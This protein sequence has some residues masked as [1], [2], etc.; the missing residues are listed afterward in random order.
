MVN[1]FSQYR[2]TVSD[3]APHIHSFL[4]NENKVDK[5]T[6]WLINWIV[7]S[8]ECGKIKPYDFLP[9][10]ADLAFHIGV[11]QGTMQNVFRKLEDAGYIE[12]KQR[13][14]SYIKPKNTKN[15]NEKLTSKREFT[16]ELLKKFIKENNYKI[17]DKFESSRNLAKIFD[18][19][20]ST[21][22][23]AMTKLEEKG[24]LKKK[25]K[26]YYISKLDFDI[27]KIETKTLAEKIAKKI[28]DYIEENLKEGDKIPTNIEFKK[29]Y[30]VSLKTIHD[31][32]KILTK[33]GILYTRR[34][35]YGTIV[36]GEKVA[37]DEY[38]YEKIEQKI[39]HLISNFEIGDKLPPIR[40]L[41]KNYNTSEKTIKKALD[42]LSDDGYIAF[43]RG[44]YGGTFV[45]D[46]PQK[47]N[48]AY[49]WLAISSKYLS[50]N[51]N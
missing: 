4:P 24:I 44:R 27:S 43:A 32:I 48:E 7:L 1:N 21:I 33:K 36:L 23:I 10:K 35:Y 2:I 46:I 37:Q 30:K 26:S 49:K 14:G 31:A 13:I 9:P 47:S 16:V 45:T 18:I 29:M 41:A 22:T 17:G 39:K 34:G 3:M 20:S 6:K 8:L 42:N 50:E 25:I 28:E 51:D 15:R 19:S 38:Y 12:S 11:S 40:E 5:L